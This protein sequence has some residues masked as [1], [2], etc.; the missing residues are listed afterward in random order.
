MLSDQFIAELGIALQA[1]NHV[2]KNLDLAISE[3]DAK[4]TEVEQKLSG[5]DETTNQ[6]RDIESLMEELEASQE[7]IETEDFGDFDP[8]QILR[9]YRTRLGSNL[10]LIV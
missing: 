1:Q 7:W 2:L 8:N 4:L 10:P 9:L 5:G 6:L 3:I